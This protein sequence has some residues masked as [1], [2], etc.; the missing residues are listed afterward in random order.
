MIRRAFTQKA[1]DLRRWSN[2]YDE[3]LLLL[4][5]CY[6]LAEAFDVKAALE[7]LVANSE[8]ECR[9]DRVLWWE[10]RGSSLVQ[11]VP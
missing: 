11:M 10:T 2:G 4:L 5:N 3:C 9:F 6:P 7:T 8:R 1:E